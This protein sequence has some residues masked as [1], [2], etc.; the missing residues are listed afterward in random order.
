MVK[1]AAM[2]VTLALVVAAG[3]GCQR[4]DSA[5]SLKERAQAYWG[6][7]QSKSWAEIYDQYLDPAAKARLS[8]EAFLKRRFL[9]FDILSY[10]ITDVQEE[11]DKAAVEV[12]NEVNFPL[13][14]PDG[15]LKLIK[16]QV[17]T[18][19]TWVRHEGHWYVQLTE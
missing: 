7:K 15:E 3:S 11:G 6:L 17:N 18:K 4:A 19:D 1:A 10:E 12:S 14:T 5:A 16:K 2:V 9:A 8:K 13:K